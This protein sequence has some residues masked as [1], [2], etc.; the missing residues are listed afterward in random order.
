MA[1]S[2]QT[3]TILFQNL[4]KTQTRYKIKLSRENTYGNF[5]IRNLGDGDTCKT[6]GT[7]RQD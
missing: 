7:S 4:P 2:Q 6:K 1:K 3:H 5:S